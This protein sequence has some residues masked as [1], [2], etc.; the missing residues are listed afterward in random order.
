MRAKSA[1]ASIQS[2]PTNANNQDVVT[3]G[4]IAARRARDVVTDVSRILAI[5]A[6]CVAQ[7]VELRQK[8]GGPA[9]SAAAIA[10]HAYVRSQIAFLDEDRPLSDEIEML[11]SRLLTNH[12]E[13]HFKACSEI[14]SS[15]LEKF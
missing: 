10:L 11:A 15:A 1:P 5:Q 2:V 7:A 4:T 13:Q 12:G 14:V 9:F 6:M 8:D 3:M